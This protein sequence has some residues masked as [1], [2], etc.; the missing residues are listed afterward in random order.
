MTARVLICTLGSTPQVVTETVWALMHDPRRPWTP[1]RIDI[2]TTNDGLKR[3]SEAL[4]HPAGRLAELFPS[5]AP[6]V[7]IWPPRKADNAA[8]EP[9]AIQWPGGQ[10]PQRC[11]NGTDLTGTLADVTNSLD[12]EVMGDLI[13]DRIWAGIQ[14]T[15]GGEA[16]EVHVSLAGGRKTM[17]AHALLALA[18]LGRVQDEASHVLVGPREFEN[19][20][21]FW[22]KGQS[23]KINKP[24]E[25]SAYRQSGVALPEALLEPA[26]A[27]IT[28]IRVPTPFVTE[29]RAK[30]RAVLAQLRLSTIIW[31][32]DIANRFQRDP[33]VAFHDGTNE[34]TICGERRRL[35]AVSYA[36]LRFLAAARVEKWPG[37]GP[38][39]YQGHEG[40]VSL[41]MMKRGVSPGF[42][43]IASR[44]WPI[45]RN[46][47]GVEGDEIVPDSKG[48]F[49]NFTLKAIA[50]ITALS[51]KVAASEGTMPAAESKALSEQFEQ[52]LKEWF[53]SLN[54]LR[55]AVSD[56]FG[57]P[58]VSRLIPQPTK[59]DPGKTS[60][61]GAPTLRF[62]ISCAPEVISIG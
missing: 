46:A 8:Q 58:L 57:L 54:G 44:L 51:A 7:T 39:G 14:E 1:T 60:T 21:Q 56:K 12:A 31:Q 45:V 6:P 5:G 20:E 10:A 61:G 19:N 59:K 50:G 37:A 38:G 28:L 18:L 13:K 55:T 16:S 27:D 23:G 49:A 4:Q 30:D 42:N 25:I 24:V 9:V 2:V 29:I 53:N 35:P 47:I 22:H 43:P 34:V 40:W 33:S 15:A 32:I 36:Q 52:D 62:G 17:S 48:V 3:I 26:D 41:D 11:L